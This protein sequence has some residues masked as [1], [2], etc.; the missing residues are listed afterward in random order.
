M[1]ASTE[2]VDIERCEPGKASEK[3]RTR[4]RAREEALRMMTAS[5]EGYSWKE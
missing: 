3:A 2:T 4:R 1:P 5:A